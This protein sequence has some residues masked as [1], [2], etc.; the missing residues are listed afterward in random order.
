MFAVRGLGVCFVNARSPGTDKGY[1]VFSLTTK[2]RPFEAPLLRMVIAAF[3]FP[4]SLDKCFLL[5][6]FLFMWDV[7]LNC[8]YSCFQCV[9]A[10]SCSASRGNTDDKEVMV[11]EFSE[12]MQNVTLQIF[13]MHHV[14]SL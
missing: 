3:L 8:S 9:S 10:L 11:R 5:C 14:Y 4:I 13:Y 12:S 7:P 6:S 1:C 2:V